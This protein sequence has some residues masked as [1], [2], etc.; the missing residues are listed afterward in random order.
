MSYRDE[1]RRALES[2][3]A[4]SSQNK[5][6]NQ[7][8]EHQP[9]LRQFEGVDDLLVLLRDRA[10]DPDRK[11]AALLALVEEHQRG[12]GTFAV[13]LLAMLPALDR[14]YRMRVRA[15]PDHDE[16][17]ARIVSSFLETLDRYPTRRRRA[18]VAANLECD[19]LKSLCGARMRETRVELAT[20]GIRAQ[21]EPFLA[22]LD[23]VEPGAHP[24]DRLWLDDFAEKGREPEAPLNADEVAA[25]G[26]AVAPLFDACRLDEEDRFLILGAH[27][28]GRR[29]GDIAADLKISRYAAKARHARAI[30]RL[31][32]LPRRWRRSR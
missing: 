5:Q 23:R 25:V 17:W 14:A 10:A 22:E 1:A 32:A 16:L 31:R 29:L 19:T 3:A 8:Q 2:S 7:A 15:A 28:Y 11:D 9:V 13:L 4:R 18:R 21:V 30:A 20:D 27:L 26:T 12:A 6:L 24:G